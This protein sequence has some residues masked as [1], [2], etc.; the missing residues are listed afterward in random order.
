MS[1]LQNLP[2]WVQVFIAV[3]LAAPGVYVFWKI[4]HD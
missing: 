4:A 3:A 2:T 1:G